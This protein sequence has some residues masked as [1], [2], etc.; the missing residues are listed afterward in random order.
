MTAY[1]QP[2]ESPQT[3]A[4]KGFEELAALT[5][6]DRLQRRLTV[7]SVGWFEVGAKVA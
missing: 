6:I 3:L 7:V 2:G 5:G 4:Q 1:S